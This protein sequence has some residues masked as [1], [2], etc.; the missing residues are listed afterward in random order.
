ME[1]VHFMQRDK[2]ISVVFDQQPRYLRWGVYYVTVFAII[3]L[4]VFTNRE[5]IY[6]QF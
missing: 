3:Y 6:F 2:A 5:F 1:A 4:G